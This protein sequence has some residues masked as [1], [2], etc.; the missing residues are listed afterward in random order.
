MKPDTNSRLLKWI[1]LLIL[2]AVGCGDDWERVASELSRGQSDNGGSPPGSPS[3]DACADASKARD[4]S[5]SADATQ[6]TDAT[7]GADASDASATTDA[8]ADG[9]ST[10]AV[11][12]TVCGPNCCPADFVCVGNMSCDPVCSGSAPLCGG[13]CC[14]HAT[15]CIDNV[16]SIGCNG[17]VCPDGG[18]CAPGSSCGPA[19]TIAPL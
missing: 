19:G 4:A 3:V 12:S 16:C 2:A 11:G 9:E 17:G 5:E 14:P 8:G 7:P 10:C 18:A 15:L 6:R 1:T 13:A